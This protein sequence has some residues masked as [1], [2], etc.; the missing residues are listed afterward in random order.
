LDIEGTATIRCKNCLNE[1]IIDGSD[2][3]VEAVTATERSMGTEVGYEAI[4]EYACPKCET[5]M[6]I[7]YEAWE[8]PAGAFNYGETSSIGGEVVKAFEDLDFGKLD[9]LYSF[10]EDSLIHLSGNK[11]IITSLILGTEA[12]IQ[13]ILGDPQ[14]IYET[15]PREFEEIIRHVFLKHNFSVELTKQTRDG[16]RDIIALKHELGIPLKFIIECKRWARNRHVGVDV[17]RNLYGVHKQEGANKSIVVT[18]SSFTRDAKEFASKIH[19][20]KW[21]MDLKDF[22]DV[23]VWLSNVS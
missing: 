21:D 16:G 11:K 17:V 8:Y 6:S 23:M 15:R 10:D 5:D 3:D 18:T 20:T 4:C 2:F 14:R 1:L 19:T 9:K 22:N 7:S 12:L 13:E